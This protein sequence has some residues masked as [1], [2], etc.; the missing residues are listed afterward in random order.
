MRVS[1]FSPLLQ[2]E[3]VEGTAA[4]YKDHFGFK[5]MFDSDWYVH[6]QS[7]TDPSLNITVLRADHETIPEP[8]RGV[9]QGVILSFEVADVDAEHER[10][11]QEGVPV[12][13]PL[14]DE[15]HGQRHAIYSDPNGILIDIITPIP[16][17]AEFLAGYAKEALPV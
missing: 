11:V 12:V 6:L 1:Q 7:K 3:D 2:T 13:Q 15:P 4:F 17:S 14:R 9:T 5:P 8:A 16:P 10:L